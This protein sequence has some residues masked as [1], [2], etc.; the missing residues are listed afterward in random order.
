MNPK[1]KTILVLVIVLLPTMWI[2]KILL[3]PPDENRKIENTIHAAV[4]AFAAKKSRAVAEFLT[5]DFKADRNVDKEMAEM[6]MKGFFFQVRDLAASIE[7]FKH[8][9]EKLPPVATEARIL[10]VVKVAGT[11]DGNRFQAFGQH[12]ADAALLSL[13]KQKDEWKIFR[14]R[15][16][17]T[18]DPLEAFKKLIE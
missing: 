12:G 8:E 4:D 7:Y 10:V 15:Y 18:K 16:I 13:R 3:F 1:L 5:D 6:Q 11:I 14:A 17:D 2:A 9:R